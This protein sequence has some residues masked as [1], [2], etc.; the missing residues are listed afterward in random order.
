MT[1]ALAKLSILPG[2]LGAISRV[3]CPNIVFGG[4]DVPNDVVSALTFH[5][6]V[7][8]ATG[9]S[10]GGAASRPASAVYRVD[11]C[12]CTATRL[13]PLGGD[14]G[15]VGSITSYGDRGIFGMAS[16]N[17]TLFTVDPVTGM[18]T[19]VRA[20]SIDV[21]A[22]GITWSGAGRDTLWYVT[23]PSDELYELD[24]L[25][26]MVSPPLPLD[27]DFAGLG[28]EYHPGDE[29]LFACSHGRIL[30]IDTTNGHVSVGQEIAWDG[31]CANLAAPFGQV[32]C[33]F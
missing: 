17:D 13:G 2:E 24:M 21:G 1:H 25:G 28:M 11:P 7:L 14:L 20:L 33:V 4:P 18:G 8:Y 9:A 6:E 12:T 23:A 5:G 15:G 3:V 27:Y 22:S 10:E 30:E 16:T 19:V 29:R 31:G 32:D 26:E